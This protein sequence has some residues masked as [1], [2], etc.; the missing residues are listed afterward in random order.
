MNL[1]AAGF[2]ID[3]ALQALRARFLH[4]ALH[5]RVDAA[6]YVSGFHSARHLLTQSRARRCA[7]RAATSDIWPD[8]D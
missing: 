2:R 4:H 6:E 3:V 1:L 5:R 8:R 7:A